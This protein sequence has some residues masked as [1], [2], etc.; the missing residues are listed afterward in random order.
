M[1]SVRNRV[2]EHRKIRN[3]KL[4]FGVIAVIILII[5][6]ITVENRISSKPTEVTIYKNEITDEKAVFIPVK[7]LDT[8][9]IAVKTIDGSYRLAFNDCIGCYQQFGV[10]GKFKN[11]SDNTGLICD[12]CKSEVM[13]DEM[14]Y[15]AEE[16]MPYPIPEVEIESLDDKFVI[17]ADYLEAKKQALLEMRSGKVK[18]QY[19]ENPNK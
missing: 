18:N 11:N 8:S 4:L 5:V 14:G 16:S 9:I 12:N 15:L 13:Y 6:A 3:K 19:S 7:Q 10:R 1:D 17:S 2:K